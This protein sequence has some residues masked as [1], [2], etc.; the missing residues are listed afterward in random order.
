ML[1][2]PTGKSLVK[3]PALGSLG[4]ASLP[5]VTPLLSPSSLPALVDSALLPG[6]SGSRLSLETLC[7]AS[8][9]PLVCT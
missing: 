9:D 3:N 7:F 2:S 1:E 8:L 5:A 6:A 4:K